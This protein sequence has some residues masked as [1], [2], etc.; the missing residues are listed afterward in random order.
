MLLV[1]LQ[2]HFKTEKNSEWKDDP[3][4][5]TQKIGLTNKDLNQKELIMQ[6]SQSSVEEA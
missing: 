4:R 5:K 3:S 6:N 1:S 2:K